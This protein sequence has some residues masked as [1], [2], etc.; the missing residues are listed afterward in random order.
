MLLSCCYTER[1]LPLSTYLAC[2]GASRS[3]LPWWKITRLKKVS[4]DLRGLFD[5]AFVSSNVNL[6]EK[7]DFK[8]NFMYMYICSELLVANLHVLDVQHWLQQ[9]LNFKAYTYLKQSM[10][11]DHIRCN[12]KRDKFVVMYLQSQIWS[13]NAPANKRQSW[14]SLVPKSYASFS[15][16]LYKNRTS[17]VWSWVDCNNAS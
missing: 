2:F 4:C 7:I 15:Q 17:A 6:S 13:P 5:K 1:Q 11:W 8:S 12:L 9:H 10:I 16:R 14:N 3:V